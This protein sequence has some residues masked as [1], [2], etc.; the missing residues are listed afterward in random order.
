M[1]HGYNSLN[2]KGRRITTFGLEKT[3]LG[4]KFP[5]DPGLLN[6][7]YTHYSLALEELWPEFQF[8]NTRLSLVSTTLNKFY[9]LLLT[10]IWRRVHE[11]GCGPE[12]SS[13]QRPAH[14]SAAA[15]DYLKTRFKTLPHPAYS[16][17][18]APCDSL[19]NPIIK[20]DL[21]DA[22]ETRTAVGRAS[23]QC[24]DSIPKCDYKSALKNWIKCLKKCVEVK[25]EYFEGL[26]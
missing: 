4:P 13:R 23:F 10:T 19:L 8:L 20:S 25:G 24:T 17:D 1:K 16:P 9:L 6:M 12:A 2:L 5:V 22:F 21:V 11:P 15:Q 14:C 26:D 3:G 18:L 7:F